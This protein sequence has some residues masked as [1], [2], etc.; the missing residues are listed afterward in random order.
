MACLPDSYKMF[1][2]LIMHCFYAT[3]ILCTCDL[4]VLQDLLPLLPGAIAGEIESKAANLN[5]LVVE[6]YKVCMYSLYNFL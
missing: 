1:S 6:A 5:N 4:H 3:V 2:V